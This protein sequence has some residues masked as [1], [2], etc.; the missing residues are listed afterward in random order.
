MWAK[1]ELISRK[2][3]CIK[4]N[5]EIKL[6]LKKMFHTLRNFEVDQSSVQYASTKLV[7]KS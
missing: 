3:A 6:K 1:I 2:V 4:Q 7:C 5:E